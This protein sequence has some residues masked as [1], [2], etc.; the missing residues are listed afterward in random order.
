MASPVRAMPRS[1]FVFSLFYGGMVC[2]AGVLGNKQIGLG[3]FSELG[4]KLG[5]P[6]LGVEAGIFA[7]LL[8]VVT[9]SSIAEIHDRKTANA[10]VGFGFIP[11]IMSMLLLMLVD[12]LPPSASMK[13]E[14]IAA[15]HM[16]FA[17]SARLMVAGVIA[18]GVS[19]T[20]NV[21]IFAWLKGQ[22][23]AKLLWLRAAVASTMSQIVDTLLFITISFVGVF[24]IGGI[25]VGQMIVKVALSI[26]LVP[27][28]IYVA[29]GL[30][31][32]LDGR[33]SQI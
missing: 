12:W 29:V 2:T 17:Q 28:F 26:V 7:F 31:R 23:G 18:Y 14:T 1:L 19:Q 33:R 32:W 21:T 24:P 15:T 20:L 6:P 13:P 25:L 11:L 22:E 8:L 5:L 10:L 3:S 4:P 30:G 16:I 27:P 9:S